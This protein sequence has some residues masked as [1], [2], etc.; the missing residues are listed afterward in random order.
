MAG[1]CLT[2]A[3]YN[4]LIAIAHYTE[5]IWGRTQRDAYL[6][7]LDRA[8]RVLADRPEIGQA[9]DALASGLRSFL[10]EAMSFF[11]CRS[12]RTLLS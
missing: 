9:R 6:R 3:A 2:P 4:S 10:K 5:S 8:F 11:T 7:K 12:S 1:F